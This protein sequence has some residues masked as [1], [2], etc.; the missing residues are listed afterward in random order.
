MPTALRG[1]ACGVQTMPTQSRG[2]G[3]HNFEMEGLLGP[4]YAQIRRAQDRPM[5]LAITNKAE[6]NE[7]VRA[8][9]EMYPELSTKQ[10][11]PRSQ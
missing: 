6:F 2:H 3:T 8:W 10:H 5:S 4:W 11:R 7:R 1:H 9:A